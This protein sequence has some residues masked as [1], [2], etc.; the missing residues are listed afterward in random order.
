MTIERDSWD[1]SQRSRHKRPGK[2]IWGVIA[3]LLIVA[4]PLA[5]LFVV[6][7]S[8]NQQ[9]VRCNVT[10]TEGIQGTRFNASPWSVAIETADCGRLTYVQ[11]VSETNVEKI[12]AS[13]EPGRYEFKL[14]LTSR[15]ATEGW[16]PFL[17]PAVQEY[18][19][20]E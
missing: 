5:I 7:E 11:G 8:T 1:Q 13:F 20:V 19:Q 16:I 3:T 17:R 14:G 10:H 6:L 2:R 18:R 4:F 15:L 12:A 9:W